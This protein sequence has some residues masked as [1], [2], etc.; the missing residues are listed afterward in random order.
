M[1]PECEPLQL[2]PHALT[3]RQGQKVIINHQTHRPVALN[4]WQAPYFELLSKGQ[5]VEQLTLHYLK[6]GMLIQFQELQNLIKYLLEEHL[7]L[8]PSWRELFHNR[9]RAL[10]GQSVHLDRYNMKIDSGFLKKLPFFYNLDESLNQLFAQHA[11]VYRAPKNTRICTQ[12]HKNRDLFALIKGDAIIVKQAPH[13][14]TVRLK[15]PA[16]FG[17]GGFF[18]NQPRGADVISTTDIELVRIQHNPEFDQIVK[19]DKFI[20]LQQRFWLLHALSHSP[21]FSSMPVETWHELVTHGKLQQLPAG[22]NILVENTWGDSFCI[23]VQGRLSVWQKG[24]QINTIEQGHCV[25]E[26]AL[27]A[28]QGRRTATVRCESPSLICEIKANQLYQLIACNLFLAT[29]LQNI[30]MKRLSDDAKR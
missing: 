2:A 11:Q 26:I 19:Q 23:L 24:T 16:I 28:T 1:H 3:E 12:G 15:A 4:E 9:D 7:L 6:Q 25:G 8:N 10:I 5:T 27:F 29:T 14:V 18:L 20:N 21:L 30:A 13:Q 22:H 17:E